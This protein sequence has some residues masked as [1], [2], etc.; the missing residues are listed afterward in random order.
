[1]AQGDFRESCPLQSSLFESMRPV[2]SKLPFLALGGN[3]LEALIHFA[4]SVHRAL[5]ANLL[6]GKGF[7]AE[8][9]GGAIRT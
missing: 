1:M 9:R 6:H 3:W 4:N 8:V 5:W 2:R 7:P